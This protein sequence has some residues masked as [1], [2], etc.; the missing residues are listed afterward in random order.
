MV[1]FNITLYHKGYFGYIEGTMRYICKVLTIVDNDSDFWSFEA[2]EQ[3]CRL[4]HEDGD[5]AAMWY[6]D[7]AI[8]DYSIGL[9]MFLDNADALDIVRI[10]VERGHVELFVVHKDAPGE[11]FPEIG[12]VDVGGDPQREN[13][14]TEGEVG[15]NEEPTV[16]DGANGQ[17]EEPAAVADGT[18][19]KN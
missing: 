12:Y 15:P 16:A 11:G 1:Y 10:G 9:R 6:K 4:G 2:A 19:G 13:D 18:L 3:L 5:V 7:P 14:D 8:Q 17:N